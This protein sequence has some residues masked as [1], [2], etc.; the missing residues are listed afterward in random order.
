MQSA[1][2]YV[3]AVLFQGVAIAVQ[4]SLSR[5]AGGIAADKGDAPVALLNQVLDRAH[6]PFSSSMPTQSS[7]EVFVI[8]VGQH[9]RAMAHDGLQRIVACARDGPRISPSTSRSSMVWMMRDCLSKSSSVVAR[10][11]LI[12]LLG[13]RRF[14]ARGQFGAV[15]IRTSLTIRADGVGAL[16]AQAGGALIVDVSQR[17]DRV[18]DALARGVGDTRIVAE[19]QR[20][21]CLGDDWPPLATSFSVTCLRL[22]PRRPGHNLPRCLAAS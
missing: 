5:G 7:G 18:Q 11:R 4:A 13:Q 10:T 9:Q 19:H 2:S 3:D 16:R 12:V 15:G 20:R 17:F 6:V 8:G 22:W 1:G 14:R 21:G